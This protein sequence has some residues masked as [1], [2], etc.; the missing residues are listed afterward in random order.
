MDDPPCSSSSSSSLPRPRD[1]FLSF[2]GEDT[3]NNFVTHLYGALQRVAVKVYRDDEELKKGDDLS[4][5]FKAIEESKISVVV[6]SE[7]YATSKW[8]LNELVKIMDCKVNQKQTVIPIFYRVD[9][10]HV[11]KQTG[12]FG[13][14]FDEHELSLGKDN[15][16]V[17]SWSDDAKLIDEIVESVFNK[18]L[19]MP[20]TNKE[21]DLVGME[22]CIQKMELGTPLQMDKVRRIGISGMGGIGKTTIATAVYDQYRFSFDKVCFVRDVKEKFPKGGVSLLKEILSRLLEMREVRIETLR[23]GYSIMEGLSDTTVLAV[24]DDVDTRD[25]INTL[26]DGPSFGGGSRII[27]TTRHSDILSGFEEHKAELSG[28]SDALTLF[29]QRAFKTNRPSKEF[30]HLSQ[31][32]VKYA[33]GLPLALKVIGSLLGDMPSAFEWEQEL[34]K[35]KDILNPD[36]HKALIISYRGLDYLA[37]KIFLDIACFFRGMALDYVTKVLDIHGFH[38]KPGIKTL[39]QR[40]LVTITESGNVEMH[41]LLQEMGRHVES[42]MKGEQR[43]FWSEDEVVDVLIRTT[44]TRNVEGL[45]MELQSKEERHFNA[46]ALEHMRN[47]RLLFFNYGP[48]YWGNKGENHVKGDLRFLSHKLSVLVWH[49]YPLKCLPSTFDPK[50]FFQLDMPGSRIEHLWE[51]DKRA[52]NLTSINLTHCLYLK[53]TPDLTGLPNLE[54]LDLSY[55]SLTEV[56]PSVFAHKNLVFLSLTNCYVLRSLPSTIRMKSLKTLDLSHCSSLKMFP[57]VPE[58]MEALSK[59]ALPGT[60]IKEL[61]SSIDRFRG[62]ES[63]DMASCE[64]LIRLPD[65]ICNLA[66]LRS[67]NLYRCSKLSKLPENIGNMEP[68]LDLVVDACGLEQ[69]PVSILRLKFGGRLSFFLCKMAAPF[70][71]WPSSIEDRCTDVVHLDF[72]SCNM[73]K[74]SDA[75]ACFPSLKVLNL[76]RN[77]LESLPAAMKEL[78]CLEWLELNGCRRLI[79]IPELSSS[80][81]YINARDCTDLVTVITPQSPYH[82]GRCFNFSNCSKQVQEDVFRDIAENHFPPQGN[83]S[84]PFSFFCPGSEIPEQF[85]HHN[86][87]ASV[88]AK[89]PPNWFNN[90]NKFTGFAICAVTNKA[91]TVRCLCTFKGDHCKYSFSFC[92]FKGGLQSNHMFVGYVP[93]SELGINGEQGNGRCYTEAKFEIE[94]SLYGRHPMHFVDGPYP[95]EICKPCIRS[96]GVR[97]FFGN[98]EEDFGEPMEQVDDS[99]WRGLKGCLVEPSSSDWTSDTSDEDEQYRELS[100]VFK[101]ANRPSNYLTIEDHEDTSGQRNIIINCREPLE[102]WEQEV[103]STRGM[104]QGC[105]DDGYD[106]FLLVDGWKRCVYQCEHRPGCWAKAIVPTPN[107]PTIQ[108]ITYEG[109]HTCWKTQPM[110]TY[111]V[112]VTPGMGI[113]CPPDDYSWREYDQR[114]IPGSRYPRRSYYVCTPQNFGGCMAMKEVRCSE[115][116]KILKIT[117]RLRHTCTLPSPSVGGRA[118]SSTRSV[119]DQ[120]VQSPSSPVDNPVDDDDVNLLP[121]ANSLDMK[122]CKINSANRN[123]QEYDHLESSPPYPKLIAVAQEMPVE[124]TKKDSEYDEEED[125]VDDNGIGDDDD[126]NDVDYN[127]HDDYAG[128]NDDVNDEDAV[129]GNVGRNVEVEVDNAEEHGNQSVS[130]NT[131]KSSEKRELSFTNVHGESSKKRH[132]VAQ[133]Q[134][135]TD[136]APLRANDEVQSA[137][138]EISDEEY[139]MQCFGILN[140]MD[141]IDDDSY[142]KALKLFRGDPT[143]RKLFV[144]MPEKR[145]KN[146]VLNLYCT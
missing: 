91:Q 111:Q 75:I 107:N 128:F 110:L 15:D 106:W 53:V 122:R 133:E 119:Y 9:P 72:S 45:M 140:K 77:N 35:M 54:K 96:C 8:C 40:S 76:S 132:E 48:F 21:S 144:G 36:I 23:D 51:R 66:K 145:R 124:S 46:E 34:N 11:R 29:R 100:L 25:Q 93:W 92:L 88:T 6:F 13:Q 70:S 64:N 142:S 112:R 43:R 118:E 22:S 56:H 141:E 24:L 71:S 67:L 5:L 114:D 127:V 90:N 129:G 126:D 89:L 84:Q 80:I 49:R 42:G 143:L 4:K 120:I 101:G 116:Q 139:L 65:S 86:T 102:T 57:D 14:A 2:R 82:I 16:L 60:A 63:L 28:E 87:G 33:E 7:N 19:R 27:V 109:R 113:E 41:D 134:R 32:A 12:S 38:P 59:L 52:S 98:N 115:D 123:K 125:D 18:L 74:L 83:P 17:Q 31:R 26:L 137:S 47:L 130:T 81:S 105:L 55:S 136:S 94:L 95:K 30:E 146:F 79:S 3:R 108:K 85:I 69:L 37:Q 117:Y 39:V 104:M 58:Y 50:N 103:R 138:K 99:E 73:M 61:P 68:L 131:E 97:F 44:D 20:S 10:S 1:V 62:L 121:D 78:G 135:F